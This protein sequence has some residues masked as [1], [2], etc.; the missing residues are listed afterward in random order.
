MERKDFEGRKTWSNYYWFY[1]KWHIVAII[2][3]M[4]T[5]IICT[6]Q[7][8]SK[9]ETDYYVLFY[10]DKY[11]MDEYLGDICDGINEYGEDLTGD[12]EVR[13]TAVNC[14]YN[15]SDTNSYNVTHQK[16]LT[17]MQPDTANI[18]VLNEVGAKLYYADE[19][20][21]LFAKDERLDLYDN[22]AI[23]AKQLKGIS[24]ISNNDEDFYVFFKKDKNGKINSDTDKLLKK[25]IK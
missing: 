17:Q 14:T 12:G 6:T 16:A 11:Y 3:F 25:L 9:V 4:I 2:F 19:K 22:H 20:I 7:C 10:S 21:D 13:V 5:I 23:N 18:W 1:Y 8:S 15:I 24:K